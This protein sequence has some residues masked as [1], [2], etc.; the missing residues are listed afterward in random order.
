MKVWLGVTVGAEVGLGEADWLGGL[1]LE[2]AVKEEGVRLPVAVHVRVG[3]REQVELMEQVEQD[4]VPNEGDGVHEALR[5]L[6]VRV[7]LRE[8]VNVREKEKETVLGEGV[9]VG[10]GVGLLL[11]VGGEMVG[12]GG[13]GLGVGVRVVQVGDKKEMVGER[14]KETEGV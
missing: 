5:G 9:G 7:G 11:G 6:G 13:L 4:A 1:G 2:E 14:L 3:D 12:E 8:G 10:G